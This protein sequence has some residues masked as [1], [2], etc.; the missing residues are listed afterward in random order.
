MMWVAGRS[1]ALFR[2]VV[3]VVVFGLAGALVVPDGLSAV[4]GRGRCRATAFVTNAGSGTVSTIDV[5]TRTKDPTDIP[6]GAAPT[7][8][9]LTPDGKTAFVTNQ[10]SGS[11]STIDVKTRTKDPTDIPVGPGPPGVAVT[12]DGKTAFFA[13]S[14]GP[15]PPFD[16]GF[17]T[18]STIDVKTRTKDPN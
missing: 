10:A 17:N 1:N 2:W 13:N 5:K 15:F 3:R 8:V 11:V 7:W 6:V 9:A 4:A 14:S 18:V 12:P 16:P